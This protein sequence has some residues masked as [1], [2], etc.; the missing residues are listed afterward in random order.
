LKYLVENKIHHGKSEVLLK[1]IEPESVAVSFWSPPYFVGKQYEKDATYES[2]RSMLREVIA[3]HFAVLKPGGFLVINIGDIRCFK[4]E[5]IPRFQAMN[6]SMHKSA[7]T[8]EMVLEAKTE[9]PNMS[10]YDLAALLGCSEQ[11]I[12]RRLNG[13]NIR[14]GKYEIQTRMNLVGGYLQECALECGLY[15]YDHRIWVKDPAWAN[16]K[17]TSNSLKAV[18]EFEDLYVF[19]KPGQQIFDRKKLSQAEWREWGMRG[20]WYINSVRA[21]DD[22]EAKFPFELA[23]RVVRLYSD[24]GDLVLDPFMG[25]GT[26][27]LAAMKMGRKFIGVEKEASYVKLATENIEVERQQ[28]SLDV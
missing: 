27:A 2:W 3:A 11:T 12:D 8:R 7:V 4:D 20:V 14:G 17:W 6:I 21:N 10:R 9:N 18:D 15:G 13:N 24:I 26:T 22:H 5:S 25:S 28:L 1:Q 16:C 23:C 19:W